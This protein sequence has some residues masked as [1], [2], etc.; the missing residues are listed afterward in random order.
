MSFH[1]IPNLGFTVV[2]SHVLPFP[3]PGCFSGFPVAQVIEA[4]ECMDYNRL[5]ASIQESYKAGS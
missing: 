5:W 4:A 3:V 1:V 2:S